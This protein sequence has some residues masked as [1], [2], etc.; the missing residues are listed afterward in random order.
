MSPS[1][2]QHVFAQMADTSN[3]ASDWHQL[4]IHKLADCTKLHVLILMFFFSDCLGQ[5]MNFLH[6]RYFTRQ[7]SKTK[8]VWWENF[9]RLMS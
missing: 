7:S 4:T 1:H 2:A 5:K 6:K 9:I 3:T 8:W